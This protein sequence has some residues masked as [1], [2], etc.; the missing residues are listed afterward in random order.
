MTTDICTVNFVIIDFSDGGTYD[1]A[2]SIGDEEE[3][4]IQTTMDEMD[5]ADESSPMYNSALDPY[6]QVTYGNLAEELESLKEV[7]C[8]ASA[9][10]L[11]KLLGT[12]C[13]QPGCSK[14]LRSV[15]VQ[16]T[17]GYTL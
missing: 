16:T 10:T 7:K 13:R 14:K 9:S 2:D 3:V 4:I 1:G 5:D 6:A 15:E 8:V 11:I 12:H 17:C